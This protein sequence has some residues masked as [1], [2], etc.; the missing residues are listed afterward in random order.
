MGGEVVVIAPDQVGTRLDTEVGMSRGRCMQ[1]ASALAPALSTS[2]CFSNAGKCRQCTLPA[3]PPSCCQCTHLL[4][5]A[6]TPPARPSHH[7]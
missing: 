4:Q 7:I 1:D 6:R 3:L 2:A 5:V